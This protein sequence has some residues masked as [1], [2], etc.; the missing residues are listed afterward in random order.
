MRLALTWS[1]TMNLSAMTREQL[2]A[3]VLSMKAKPQ[4]GL[5]LKVAK[6]GGISLYGMGRFPTTLY[7]EQWL[8]VLDNQQEI[9]DFIDTNDALLSQGKDDPRFAKAE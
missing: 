3:M 4:R 8:R 7:K 6:G 1:K 2:E 9:R 5:I